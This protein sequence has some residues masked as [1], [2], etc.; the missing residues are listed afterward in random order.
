[1]SYSL[2][3][4]LAKKGY[5]VLFISHKPYFNEPLKIND[6]PGFIHVYSWPTEKRPTGIK[7][8]IWFSRIFLK[9]KPKTIIAHFVGSN[10]SVSVAKLLSG[11]HTKTFVYYHTLSSPNFID[12]KRGFLKTWLL[13]LRKRLFYLFFA[14]QI[15]CPSEMAKRDFNIVYENKRKNNKCVVVINPLVDRYI[16]PAPVDYNKIS[17][18]FLG[19]LDLS[20]GIKELLYGF[21]RYEKKNEVKIT[22]HLAGSGNLENFVKTI[23]AKSNNIFFHGHLKYQDVDN[24]I[25]KSHFLIIPSLVDNLPTV[26]LESL[27][28]GVPLLLSKQTGLAEYITDGEDGFLFDPSETGISEVFEIVVNNISKRETMSVNARKTYLKKFTMKIYFNRITEI[29]QLQNIGPDTI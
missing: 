27:M 14:D 17:I 2:A 5:N 20:K 21:L 8:F 19:R 16:C 22:L 9:Y 26:G 23:A 3:H 25:R 15:I 6:Y 12:S 11:G 7:D 29:L 28:N 18:A 10:I 13:K 4:H 1:M 24:Y